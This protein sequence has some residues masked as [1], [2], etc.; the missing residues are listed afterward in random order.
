MEE[1]T[2]R[3][4]INLQNGEIEVEGDKEF[5]RAE[6]EILIEKLQKLRDP[7][8][9]QPSYDRE[10]SEI[11]TKKPEIQEKKPHIREFINE[12]R[13]SGGLQT[14]VVLAYYLYKYEGKETFTKEDL[15]DIWAASGQKPTKKMWQSVIDGKNRYRWYEE[16]SRG[17]YKI[18]PHGIYFV[19]NEL[20]K[21]K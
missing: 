8:I 6:V 17:V 11:E 10:I 16:V 9:K 1:K 18:S 3:I 4:R 14:A 7:F 21:K 12:K 13:P 5:V 20:P 19:E 15:K 2:Y